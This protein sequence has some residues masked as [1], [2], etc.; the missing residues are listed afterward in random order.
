M[1]DR[2]RLK[3]H[4][5][6]LVLNDCFFQH[7]R[8][9]DAHHHFWRYKPEDLPWITENME[10]LRHDH[11]VAELEHELEFSGMDQ[12]ISVQ[13]RRTDRENQFLLEEARKSEG[14]VAGVVGWAPLDSPDLRVFLDQYIREPLLKGVREVVTGK[15]KQ[16]WLN[17][18]DVD[19]GIAE[20]KC[21]DLAFD[22]TV[23]PEQLPAAIAFADRHPDQRMVLTHCGHP[24]I[25]TQEL[26]QSWAHAIR[27]LARRPHVYCKVSGLTEQLSINSSQAIDTV[28]HSQLIQ[29]YFDTVCKAFGAKRLMYGSN[30]PICK[31]TTTYP[32]WMTTVDD[33]IFSLSDDE[34]NAIHRDTA[35]EFYRLETL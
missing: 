29:P 24:P 8:V 7:A 28:R 15:E 34:K 11:R 20:L 22:L 21:C 18:P 31:L 35:I 4:N 33:L 5:I 14:L 3:T 13:C 23:Y 1:P 6:G 19:A 25:Q 26:D 32:A 27:E 17:D 10:A 12:V 2:Q 9:I 16:S 30:W